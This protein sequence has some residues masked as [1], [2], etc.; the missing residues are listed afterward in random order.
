MESLRELFRTKLE[1]INEGKD[2]AGKNYMVVRAPWIVVDKKNRNGRIYRK[3]IVKREIDR[4]Q[5]L[6]S[7]GGFIGSA[8]HGSS[9]HATVTDASHLVTKLWLDDKGT[10]WAELKILPTS[11]GKNVMEIIKA[12]GE[13]GLSPR[14]FGNVGSDG[15]VQDDYRLMGVDIVVNPSEP[16]AVFNS[17]NVMESVSFTREM[18]NNKLISAFNESV[19]SGFQGTFEE[20]KTKHPNLVEY[21]L[22]EEKD[23]LPA[24][25]LSAWRREA[26]AAGCASEKEIRKYQEG[27]ALVSCEED[28]PTEEQWIER[29]AVILQQQLSEGGVAATFDDAK[30]ILLEEKRKKEFEQK[31]QAVIKQVVRDYQLSGGSS[32]MSLES[33]V[34]KELEKRG[35]LKEEEKNYKFFRNLF[36]KEG[37]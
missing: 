9:G 34:F 7:R 11:K 12:G 35:L 14:G 4:V 6:I 27:A 24:E 10:G 32:V 20:W 31:R 30:R 19:I 15:T 18:R 26:I 28:N 5:E 13:L 22:G 17:E 36:I 3:E 2:K 29:E 33:L 16:S 8:D 1:I 25:K 37:G 23:S 21:A